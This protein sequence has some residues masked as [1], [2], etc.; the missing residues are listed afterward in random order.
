MRGGGFSIS[1]EYGSAGKGLGTVEARSGT[2]PIYEGYTLPDQRDVETEAR[3]INEALPENKADNPKIAEGAG[4]VVR[5][6]IQSV[7]NTNEYLRGKFLRLYQAYRTNSLLT[8]RVY[9]QILHSPEPYKTVENVVPRQHN[10]LFGQYPPYKLEGLEESDDSNAMNQQ[11]MCLSQHREMGYLQL[12]YQM[13]RDRAIY[14]TVVQKLY[15]R[16]DIRKM[17]YRK[18]R[19]VPGKVP[20]TTRRELTKV[21]R[22]E[23]YFD[24]N[25]ALP[26][27]LWD[28]FVPPHANGIP[29]AEWCADRT[30]WNAPR[31]RRMGELRLWKNLDKLKDS[32]GTRDSMAFDDEFKAAKAFAYGVFDSRSALDSPHIAHWPVF[33]WWGPF[34]LLDD[35]GE[36]LTNLVIIDPEGLCICVVA[37]RHPY[38]HGKIPYQASRYTPLSEEFYG[39]GAIEPIGRL[40]LAKDLKLSLFM[41]QVDIESCPP[42]IAEDSA[43]IPDGQ[44]RAGP[45]T[46]I[47]ARSADAVKPLFMPKTSDVLIQS[48]NFLTNECRETTGITEPNL[49]Q[50]S[51]K[52]GATATAVQSDVNESNLR[53]LGGI[54]TWDGEITEP[55]LEQMTWNNQQFID[56]PKAIRLVGPSGLRFR[57]R[58]T[59]TPEDLVGRFLVVT[60]AGPRLSTQRVMTQQLINLLDR[61]PAVNQMTGRQSIKVVNLIAKI[62]HDSFGFHDVGELLELPP[63][64]K[65]LF[66]AIEE[67]ELWLHLEVA[68]VRDED[69]HLR[70]FTMHQEFFGSDTFREL[71]LNH[72]AKAGEMR[73]HAA[74]HGIR[75]AREV[76]QSERAIAMAEQIRAVQGQGGESGGRGFAEGGGQEPG[77]PKHRRE[78]GMP[79]N[80]SNAVKSEAG[81]NS[82]NQ[83]AS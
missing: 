66:S 10:Q 1:P 55:M 56:K 52:S 23:V 62:M 22:D 40:S 65:R 11:A 70:H 17:T 67:H 38:W 42:L 48:L 8:Q 69:N 61:A 4:Q 3:L 35:E 49:G 26:I 43:N 7:R 75:L 34:D 15:W 60:L 37:Q 33:D 80:E 41:R 79:E 9:G 45:G 72:P 81:F 27:S 13:L 78:S 32:P 24:G 16:Q 68:P 77:S 28:F 36:E 59:I 54:I 83:G 82:P 12:A 14:G 51:Q 71:E 20:G 44:W 19:T 73:A 2:K 53:L 57:D 31:I 6:C 5:A 25:F 58:F 39:I 76:E 18:A 50:S 29:G 63:E 47:R 21:R 74:D 64:D 30:M 46:I